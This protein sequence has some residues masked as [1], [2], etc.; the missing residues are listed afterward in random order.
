MTFVFHE[1]ENMVENEKMMVISIFS[2]SA[3]FSKAL[4]LLGCFT[5]NFIVN[6]FFNFICNVQGYMKVVAAAPPPPSYLTIFVSNFINFT[7]II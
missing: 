5:W 1:K 3:M 4:F 2:F 6:D 7:Y